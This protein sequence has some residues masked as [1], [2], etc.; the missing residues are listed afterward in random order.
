MNFTQWSQL[1]L[2][3]IMGA[4]SPGPSLAVI[5]RN[6]LS[7]GRIQGV[8]SGIGHGLGITFYAVVAV[9][10]LV[11]IINTIPHFFSV[12]QI[13][14]SFFLIWLGGKMIISFFKKDY[15][16]IENMPS[17]N[18]AHQGFLEGFLI[19]FINPKIAVWLLALFSQFVQPEALLA[20]Q[21]V[22]VSTVGVIDASWYCLVA[23]LASSGKL[24]KGLERNSSRIALGM[25]SLL[26][27]LAAGM[28]W[29]A[30]PQII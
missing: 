3:C 9:A 5:L 27:I 8:M 6:T 17:K 23:F 12:A 29:R 15:A 26:I 16:G 4:I 7:G 22:L 18:S 14:G 24:V 30:I 10:G 25:G 21:I 13:A 1:V 11:A 19:A 20:E 2:I 28:L